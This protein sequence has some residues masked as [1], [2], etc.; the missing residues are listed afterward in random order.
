MSIHCMSF[1][2][3]SCHFMLYHF[4][5]CH[6]MSFQVSM[7]FSLLP[8]NKVGR[9]EGGRGGQICLPRTSVTALLSRR[10][11]NTPD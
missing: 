5:L 4:I 6:I 9:G 8:F 10:R 11:L 3:L 1:H 2:V 7:D